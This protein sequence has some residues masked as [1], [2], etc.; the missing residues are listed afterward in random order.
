MKVDL[1]VFEERGK[2]PVE[3]LWEDQDWSMLPRVGDEIALPEIEPYPEGR[4]AKVFSLTWHLI[5]E[6]DP[7]VHIAAE[8]VSDDIPEEKTDADRP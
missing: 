8:L 2:E 4:Y 3:W 7:W 6:D 1:Q 5:D